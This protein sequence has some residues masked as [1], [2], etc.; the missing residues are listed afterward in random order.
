M[1][2]SILSFRGV[3]DYWTTFKRSTL[4]RFDPNKCEHIHV[5]MWCVDLDIQNEANFRL[6]WDCYR[7]GF[8]NSQSSSSKARATKTS[9][10]RLWCSSAD[11]VSLLR[12][13]FSRGDDFVFLFFVFLTS[14]LVFVF[15]LIRNI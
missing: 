15:E 14:S 10:R 3:L 5:C 11:I 12:L 7:A 13:Y 2:V 6:H 9:M 8:G 1:T 4:Q